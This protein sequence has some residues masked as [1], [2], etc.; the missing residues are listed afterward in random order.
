LSADSLSGPLLVSFFS[1]HVQSVTME[2]KAYDHR[3]DPP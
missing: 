1:I 3:S 2:E